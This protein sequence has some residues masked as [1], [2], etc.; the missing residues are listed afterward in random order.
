MTDAGD[1]WKEIA[2]PG[3]PGTRYR[4]LV[5]DTPVPDPTSRGQSGGIHGWSVVQAPHLPSETWKGRPWHETVLYEIHP[6]L[7]GGVKSQHDRIAIAGLQHPG[8]E[9]AL[10]Q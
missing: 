10:L 7:A 1:G 5:G 2:A 4:F 3:G 6:G 9:L 8:G